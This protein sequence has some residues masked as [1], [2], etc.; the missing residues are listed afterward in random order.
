MFDIEEFIAVIQ[1]NECIWNKRKYLFCIIL[2]IK[3]LKY[4]L[5]ILQYI[6]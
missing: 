4:F 1:T 5:V 3:R 6:Y 2:H